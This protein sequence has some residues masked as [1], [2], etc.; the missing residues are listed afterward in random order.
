MLHLTKAAGIIFGPNFFGEYGKKFFGDMH[1][2]DK[3][4]VDLLNEIY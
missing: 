4:V 1:F 3:T 2:G